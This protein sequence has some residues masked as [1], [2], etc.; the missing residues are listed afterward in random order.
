MPHLFTDS[1][2]IHDAQLETELQLLQGLRPE[3]I[4]DVADMDARVAAIAEEMA[5][6]A[7]RRA[8]KMEALSRMD[9]HIE[10]VNAERA[11]LNAT[12]RA[13]AKDVSPGRQPTN[14]AADSPASEVDK[15]YKLLK[16]QEATRSAKE[17]ARSANVVVR[18]ANLAADTPS[19]ED[20]ATRRYMRSKAELVARRAERALAP[21]SPASAKE[22]NDAALERY[23]DC[24][25]ESEQEKQTR[26]QENI[27]AKIRPRTPRPGSRGGSPA[28]AMSPRRLAKPVADAAARSLS[29]ARKKAGEAGQAARHASPLPRRDRAVVMPHA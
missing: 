19:P 3:L 18:A 11:S 10:A 12:S 6:I 21:A 29:F 7:A 4:E 8:S 28:R 2:R 23:L 25:P 16:A 14:L 9:A 13:S 26:I 17:A 27:A 1:E 24:S 20:E 22:A 5:K 15:Q